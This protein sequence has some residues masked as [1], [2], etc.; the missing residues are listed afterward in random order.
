[1]PNY[2]VKDTGFNFVVSDSVI[3]TAHGTLSGRNVYRYN[4]GVPVLTAEK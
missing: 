2:A 1:M 3:G 4:T